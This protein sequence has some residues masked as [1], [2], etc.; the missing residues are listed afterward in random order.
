MAHS[1]YM[2]HQDGR[3]GPPLGDIA[4]S[5]RMFMLYTGMGS[6]TGDLLR[7]LLLLL[8]NFNI[9]ITITITLFLIYYNYYYYYWAIYYNYYYYYIFASRFVQTNLKR[10]T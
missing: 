6:I 10:L 9:T 4:N 2:A 5:D 3:Y 8:W 7:L 1:V